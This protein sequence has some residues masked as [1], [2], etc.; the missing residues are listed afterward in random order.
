MTEN[1]SQQEEKK[2]LS[3]WII[4]IA[5]ILFPIGY[6]IGLILA[7]RKM[8]AEKSNM[9]C[10][11]KWGIGLGTGIFLV[12]LLFILV[13]LSDKEM[14]AI[15][16][17]IFSVM[18]FAVMFC[19][20]AVFLIF[21]GMTCKKLGT[22]FLLYAPFVSN[23]VTAECSL[24][25][26]AAACGR[27]YQTVCNEIEQL[28]KAGLLKDSYIDRQTRCLV[29]PIAGS[30][31]QY[32]KNQA[33]I[34]NQKEEEKNDMEKTIIA[35]KCPNCGG[36]NNVC[37]GEPQPC[38]YCGAVLT[39]GSGQPKSQLSGQSGNGNQFSKTIK[40]TKTEEFTQ[41]NESGQTTKTTKTTQS[42]D[43]EQADQLMDE[44]GKLMDNMHNI[45]GKFSR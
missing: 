17:P 36:M 43:I 13:S 30:G 21:R 19:L 9:L 26:I 1:Q 20:P 40:Y 33:T 4:L 18:P 35:V 16:G 31:T 22:A 41:S 6:F 29:S 23:A 14:V 7:F 5:C 10:N 25:T 11:G 15:S 44:F 3:W 45:M 8:S 38:E 28:I 32:V 39:Y 24:D 27:D 37:E 34:H 2:G 12:G 42:E